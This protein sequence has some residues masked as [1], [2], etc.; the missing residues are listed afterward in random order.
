MPR[1]INYPIKNLDL[2]RFFNPASPHKASSKYDLIG[3]N[4]HQEFGNKKNINA[5]HYT[6]IVKSMINNN[7]YLYNDSN[8]VIMAYTK[9]NLQ[10][11][12]A[13]LLFYYRH[14]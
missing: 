2:E 12:N 11:S 14:D 8:D 1:S 9:E 5:G 7:W 3:V 13:Y 4:L 10:N 6:S